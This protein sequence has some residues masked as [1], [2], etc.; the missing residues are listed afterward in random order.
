M[1]NICRQSNIVRKC[2]FQDPVRSALISA[3][4]VCSIFWQFI[5]SQLV[6]DHLV[7]HIWSAVLSKVEIYN[8]NYS[9]GTFFLSAILSVLSLS[10][11]VGS[12]LV[13]LRFCLTPH[14]TVFP[15]TKEY[16]MINISNAI[17]EVMGK[18]LERLLAMCIYLRSMTWLRIPFNL[19]RNIRF[20]YPTT[21]PLVGSKFLPVLRMSSHVK[22]LRGEAIE[23][24]LN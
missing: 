1:A 9:H 19:H 15:G 7:H 4:A 5:H 13:F 6:F 3:W 23:V 20:F 16:F 18:F 21:D 17:S 24:I 11:F 2:I 12:V 22:Q 10:I 8:C 14:F